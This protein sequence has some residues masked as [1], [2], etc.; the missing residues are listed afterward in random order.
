[1]KYSW[2]ALSRW[3]HSSPVP[4]SLKT[5]IP[6]INDLTAQQYGL[7]AS[8]E[9]AVAIANL[10]GKAMNGQMGRPYPRRYYLYRRSRT[11]HEVRH[12]TG[13]KRPP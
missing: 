9:N 6:A 7:N 4:D 12:R 8:Q 2:P 5:L 1:M 10:F 11:D 3:R 13:K